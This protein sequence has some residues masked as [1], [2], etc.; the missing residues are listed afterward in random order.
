[1]DTWKVTQNLTINAGL[2]YDVE[3]GIFYSNIPRPQFLAP[4]LEGQTNGVPYGLGAPKPNTTDFAP[5]IGFSYAIGKSK[6]TVIRGGA[7]MYWDSN[8]IWNHFREGGAIGPVGD[9]RTTFSAQS[10]TNI[11]P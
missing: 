6:N 3:T 4:I 10:F 5:Q 7:G 9:G 8:D 1:A 2:G 11:F